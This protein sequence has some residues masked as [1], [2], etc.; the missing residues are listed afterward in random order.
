[1]SEDLSRAPEELE[2]EAR[3]PGSAPAKKPLAEFLAD[4]EARLRDHPDEPAT[5][6]MQVVEDRAAGFRR[7]APQVPLPATS[8]PDLATSVPPA[9][10]TPLASEV[11]TVVEVEVVAEVEAVIE[12]PVAEP[13]ATDRTNAEAPPPKTAEGGSPDAPGESRRLRG[14][15]RRKHRH[16]AH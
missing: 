1:M 5:G 11:E 15:R 16:R 14:R 8:P 6:A 3:R 9:P 13:P 12:V 10:V 4:F 2:P 7:S